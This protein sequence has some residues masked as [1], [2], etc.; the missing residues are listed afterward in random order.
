M[1]WPNLKERKREL[2]GLHHVIGAKISSQI[3]ENKVGG[4][5]FIDSH[6]IV[7]TPQTWTGSLYPY[8]YFSPNFKFWWWSCMV[9]NEVVQTLK[10]WDGIGERVDMNMIQ[11]WYRPLQTEHVILVKCQNRRLRGTWSYLEFLVKEWVFGW[12][13][14]AGPHCPS[15]MKKIV[16][17]VLKLDLDRD[18]KRPLKSNLWPRNARV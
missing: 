18:G 5:W 3:L 8:M 9:G 7:L 10:H 4:S 14:V 6:I 15:L 12:C 13:V 16:Q 1:A 2:V 11:N 17:R